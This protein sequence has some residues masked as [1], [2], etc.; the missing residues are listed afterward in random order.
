MLVL[1]GHRYS[2]PLRSPYSA[3]YPASAGPWK[4]F[5]HVFRDRS[6]VPATPQPDPR[7]L[8]PAAIYMERTYLAYSERVALRQPL[9]S[10]GEAPLLRL[11]K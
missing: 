4:N 2:V 7:H 1:S 5:S 8:S 11:C 6:A 9:N 10:R 3:V